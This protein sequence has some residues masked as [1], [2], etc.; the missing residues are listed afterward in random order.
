MTKQYG[1]T[2]KNAWSVALPTVFR[3]D[4]N[5]P[6]VSSLPQICWSLLNQAQRWCFDKT[7]IN[8]VVMKRKIAT[9]ITKKSL[10]EGS[11][12]KLNHKE[13]FKEESKN[14][15]NVTVKLKLLAKKQV[16]HHI[17]VTKNIDFW[18]PTSKNTFFLKPAINSTDLQNNSAR[19]PFFDLIRHDLKFLLYLALWTCWW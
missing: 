10:M 7:W 18:L 1:K 6:A 16:P 11:S 5:T 14:F 4:S 3:T 13:E 9:E 8:Q 12:R 2:Q 15:L 19:H 17:Q